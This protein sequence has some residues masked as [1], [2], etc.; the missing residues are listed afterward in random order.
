MKDKKI[1]WS[2]VVNVSFPGIFLKTVKGFL[3]V[4]QSQLQYKIKGKVRQ[5][6]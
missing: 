4:W 6:V 1:F 3:V 5:L 2:P